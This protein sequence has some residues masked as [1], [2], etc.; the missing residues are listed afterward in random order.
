MTVLA[1]AMAADDDTVSDKQLCVIPKRLRQLSREITSKLQ[2]MTT[3]EMPRHLEGLLGTLIR[4]SHRRLAKTTQ[5]GTRAL[6]AANHSPVFC[7]WRG[8]GCAVQPDGLASLSDL[9]W[10]T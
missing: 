2:N 1:W 8:P 5:N 6:A 10:Q 9:R 3:N 4:A 7:D